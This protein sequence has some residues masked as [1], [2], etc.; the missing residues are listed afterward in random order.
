M[1]KTILTLTGVFIFS[2]IIFAQDVENVKSESVVEKI[3]IKDDTTV[4]TVITED[5]NEVKSTVILEGTGKKEQSSSEEVIDSRAERNVSLEV[6][7][8][9]ENIDA[10]NDMK[11]LEKPLKVKDNTSSTL[12]D[13]TNEVLG[14][15]DTTDEKMDRKAESVKNSAGRAVKVENE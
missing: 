6:D 1:K 12:S 5:V 4:K 2:A 11:G 14:K 13:Q 7:I 10:L 3:T 8:N 15:P 9:D